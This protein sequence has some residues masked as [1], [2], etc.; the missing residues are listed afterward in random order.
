VAAKCYGFKTGVCGVKRAGIRRGNP[1]H[2]RHAQE[3]YSGLLAQAA[4]SAGR[5]Q[6]NGEFARRAIRQGAP[7]RRTEPLLNV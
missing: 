7:Q 2:T 4:I 3:Q 1:Y 6:A 5:G